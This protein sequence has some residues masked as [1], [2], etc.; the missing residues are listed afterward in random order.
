MIDFG[1]EIDGMSERSTLSKSTDRS[2]RILKFGGTSVGTAERL[3]DAGRIIQGAAGACWPVIVVSAAGGVTDL[4]VQAADATPHI[5]D[6]AEAWSER[7]GNC[8]R[9]LADAKIGDESLRVQYE[10]TLR[11]RVSALGRALTDRVPRNS[12]ARDAVLAVGERLMAPLLVGM[13][14]DA[15]RK[16][17]AVDAAS[18]IC[19]DAD[20]GAATVDWPSTLAKIS[21]WAAQWGRAIP[22]VTGFIGST[23][24][25]VTTTL[26][27]GGS[28]YSAALL[29]RALDAD[30]LERWTDVDGLYTRNPAEHDDARRLSRIQMRKAR[31]WSEEGRL[32]LH[33]GTLDP[34]VAGGIPLRVR[35]THRPEA[36]GTRVV[37]TVS[38][39]SC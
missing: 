34:L 9:E 36:P 39:P 19:T 26:G 14:A 33:A 6:D 15:G 2:I 4:L 17:R 35:C 27:R 20:H 30:R 11:A 5:R 24:E 18:L 23:E 3:R 25:G 12:A 29:A 16:A 1:E 13:L 10:S 37:P 28:D 32:G 8:Y 38:E 31:R 21:A 22:V 7:I